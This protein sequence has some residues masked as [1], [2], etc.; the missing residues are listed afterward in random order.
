[1]LLWTLSHFLTTSL[2]LRIKG[3]EHN[4]DE[5]LRQTAN[6]DTKQSPKNTRMKPATAN[7][8]R[9]QK[10]TGFGIKALAKAYVEVKME[11]IREYIHSK[12]ARHAR[13]LR[14]MRIS[15]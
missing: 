1:M 15:V 3:E 12:V 11:N 4:S 14:I 10:A 2:K 8:K 6:I 7:G 13:K 9:T 5:S